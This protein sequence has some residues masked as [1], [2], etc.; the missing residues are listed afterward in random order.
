MNTLTQELMEYGISNRQIRRILSTLSRGQTVRTT[1]SSQ[2]N[3][4]FVNDDS[5]AEMIIIDDNG[6]E[7]SIIREWA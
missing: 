4:I 2:I 5:L 6:R 7:R 3:S 1:G